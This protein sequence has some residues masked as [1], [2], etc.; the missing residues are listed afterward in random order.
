MPHSPLP[1][2]ARIPAAA[3]SFAPASSGPPSS[4]HLPHQMRESPGYVPVLSD[5]APVACGADSAVSRG[6]RRLA[7]SP[8]PCHVGPALQVISLVLIIAYLTH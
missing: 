4:S 8:E 3:V 6:C 5:A 2:G 7:T 1:L